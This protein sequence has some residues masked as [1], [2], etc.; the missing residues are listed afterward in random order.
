M[1]GCRRS[2]AA[3]RILAVLEHADGTLMVQPFIKRAT[4][5]DETKFD[6]CSPYGYGGPVIS[7][8][9][10]DY[11]MP[12]WAGMFERHLS[13]WCEAENIVSEFCY[14]HPMMGAF[15][16][17]LVKPPTH[18][19]KNVVVIDLDKFSEQTV[20]RRVR[21]G[22]VKARNDGVMVI[23]LHDQPIMRERF[24]SLYTRAMDE[25]KATQYW[26][27]SREYLDAHYDELAARVFYASDSNDGARMLM[28][29]GGYGTAYAH[30]L[31]SNGGSPRAGLDEALYCH[32]ARIL[33]WDGYQRFHLGGGTTRDDFDPLLAFKAGFSQW[34]LKLC[35]YTKIFDEHAYREL[36]ERKAGDE[37]KQL[38]HPV[39]SDFFP[40]YRREV[41]V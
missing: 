19:V 14:L 6:L 12:E 3:S 23:E 28:V 37:I 26:R 32:A 27:F 39:S 18:I 11:E 36:A 29:I 9:A 22:V 5:Y 25:K 2:K 17:M 1:A 40:V 38:G 8:P 31:G 13:D 41:A 34:R 35:S 33:K 16:R 10:Q 20:S 21:R 15:Q 30:F 7:A 4:P 24:A